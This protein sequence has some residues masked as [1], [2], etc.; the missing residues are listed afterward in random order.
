MMV[1]DAGGTEDGGVVEVTFIVTTSF[2]R[3][4][5]L[6]GPSGLEVDTEEEETDSDNGWV[7]GTTD[8]GLAPDGV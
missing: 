8:G 2:G 4:A 1:H 5:T 7:V 6:A 3:H